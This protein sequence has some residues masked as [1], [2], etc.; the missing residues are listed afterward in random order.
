MKTN[1]T[2]GL[3]LKMRA[4]VLL[5]RAGKRNIPI[6]EYKYIMDMS[7]ISCEQKNY[8]AGSDR[9]T[10]AKRMGLTNKAQNK[11]SAKTSSQKHVDDP[12]SPFSTSRMLM[13]L[14]TKQN[15]STHARLQ[16]N[17]ASS[18]CGCSVAP[19]TAFLTSSFA[20]TK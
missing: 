9:V 10:P 6:N 17:N 7:P 20:E 8:Q 19:S 16:Y 1:V 18:R 2:L 4:W 5:A 13:P 11:N 12:W 3:A 15:D 14:P